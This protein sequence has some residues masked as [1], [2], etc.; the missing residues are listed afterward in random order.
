MRK[1]INNSAMLPDYGRETG[2]ENISTMLNIYINK[3]KNSTMI[4]GRPIAIKIHTIQKP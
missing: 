4:L 3:W 1:Y 2:Y